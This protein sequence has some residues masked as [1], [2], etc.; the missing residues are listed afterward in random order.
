MDW[1]QPAITEEEKKG[2]SPAQAGSILFVVL[3]VVV[4]LCYAVVYMNPQVAFNPFKPPAPVFP[5][6]TAAAMAATLTPTPPPTSTPE[7]PFPA[8]W[9]P[10]TTPTPTATRPPP[11]PTPTRT[12][13]FTPGPTP[14]FA[15]SYDVLFVKQKLY[16]GSEE[17]W[18]GVAGE[19]TTWDSKPVTDVTIRVWDDFGHVW[20]TQP[21]NAIEYGETYTSVYGGRGT[22]AW[23]EQFLFVSCQQSIKVHVQ[24]ISGGYKSRVITFDTTGDCEKNL[25]LVHFQKNY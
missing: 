17:W 4:L 11:T 18:S 20:E 19:V 12:P 23:W 5:T 3:T 8:T 22:Y 7:Q 1:E 24:V 15:L 21:G 14:R 16:V 2:M 25:V 13:T 10:T 9:T 6:E